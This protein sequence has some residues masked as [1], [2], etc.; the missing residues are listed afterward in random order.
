MESARKKGLR[1]LDYQQLI[2]NLEE[3]TAKYPF[4]YFHYIGSSILGKAIPAVS[5]GVG[6]RNV[7][8]IGAHHGMEWL[9]SV[10]LLRFIDDFCIQY[11]QG[12]SVGKSN[13]RVIYNTHTITVIPMLN[14][15][16][17]DYQINGVTSDNPLFERLKKANPS[18]DFG[19]WQANARGVDLN[20]N[21]DAGFWEYK[22]LEAENGI[23][24]G[25]TR[26]SGSAP[27]SEPEVAALCNLIRFQANL[28]GIMTL[29]TQGEEICYPTADEIPSST[30]AIARHLS[31]LTGYRI[32]LPEGLASYGGLSDWA[33][34]VCKI[35]CFTVEC[36]KGKNPLPLQ[37][38][39]LIYADMRH[40]F[41][42]FPTLL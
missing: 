7:F 5:L 41:F 16:G 35:P 15:D 12:K 8:Y 40:A 19:N 21:Y 24:A 42:A 17:V 13:A 28:K 29:H 9:T 14:P 31:A 32:A 11:K 34:C 4:L 26:F 2:S 38:E 10:L 20:H 36:G 6:S 1:P 22:K 3:L 18:M 25:A 30:H 33:N 23:E 37:D 27:E 39:P